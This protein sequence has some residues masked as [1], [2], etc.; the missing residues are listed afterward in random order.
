[1]YIS[2]S[3]CIFHLNRKSELQTLY[4][5]KYEIMKYKLSS[6]VILEED[7]NILLKNQDGVE[8]KNII[9]YQPIKSD[10][11]LKYTT[12]QINTFVLVFKSNVK[13]YNFYHVKVISVLL[14]D[15]TI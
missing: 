5:Y 3:F 10:R 13:I 4:G 11:F 12:S 8:K 15:C 14:I 1:M 7:R 2:K 9:A 6:R